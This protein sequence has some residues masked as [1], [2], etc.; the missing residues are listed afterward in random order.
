MGSSGCNR[1]NNRCRGGNRGFYNKIET[2]I[3]LINDTNTYVEV[4]NENKSE[5]KLSELNRKNSFQK[6]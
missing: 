4:K 6:N 2:V 3:N 1:G 5:I